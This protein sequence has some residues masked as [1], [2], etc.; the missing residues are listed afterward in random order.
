MTVEN[1]HR[2]DNKKLR[3]LYEATA[4]KGVLWIDD[5]TGQIV[6]LPIWGGGESWPAPA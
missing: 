3:E 2:D 5:A 4:K 6:E 1:K